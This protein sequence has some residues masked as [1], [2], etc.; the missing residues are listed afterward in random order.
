MLRMQAI[1]NADPRSHRTRRISVQDNMPVSCSSAKGRSCSGA[2]NYILRRRAAQMLSADA[3][4]CLPWAESA[5]QPADSISRLFEHELFEGL[6]R[7]TEAGP[8]H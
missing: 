6:P 3:S 2:L 5:L 1:L 4:S 8:A 7:V